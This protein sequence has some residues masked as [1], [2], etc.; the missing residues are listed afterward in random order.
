MNTTGILHFFST[1]ELILVSVILIMAVIVFFL[2]MYAII[3]RIIYNMRNRRVIRKKA[4]WE[5]IV[6]DYITGIIDTVDLYSLKLKTGDWMIFGAFIENYLVDL[7][8]EDNDRLIRLLW[9]I[10]YYEVL[11]GALDS[12]DAIERA[13]S[14]HYLGL[15]NYRAA[16]SKIMNLIYDSSS[17]VAISAFE[18]LN[19]IGTGKNLDRI[20]RDVLNKTDLSISKVSD[21]ILSYGSELNPVLT[22]LLD[23][24]EVTDAGKR[25]I[26]DILAYKNALDSSTVVLKLARQTENKELKIG[27]IKAL[28]VFCD[29]ESIPFLQDNISAPDWI[30]RSQAVKAFGNIGTEEI[31]PLLSGILVSD[32]NLWVKLYSAQ[33]LARFGEKG[34]AILETVLRDSKD[35]EDVIRY[36]LYET[37]V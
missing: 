29:P 12:S 1:R 2:L 18:A 7:K 23:D 30:I 11:M 37:G 25:L 14:A 35:L 21:I 28:G 6:L 4:H 31:I 15:M 8:G 17:F 20:I 10:G 13:Y 33:S 34:K 3:F 24:R 36:V 16:E 9:N 22:R 5:K 27:C 32:D 26:V 19:R